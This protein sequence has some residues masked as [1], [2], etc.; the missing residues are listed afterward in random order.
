M[1]ECV[2]AR[3]LC[4]VP[5]QVNL[6]LSQL[7]LLLCLKRLC[8]CCCLLLPAG[9]AC[10]CWCC[11]LLLVLPAAAGAEPEQALSLLLPAAACCCLLPASAAC[12]CCLLV[13]GPHPACHVPSVKVCHP[14]VHPLVT[15]PPSPL[16]TCTEAEL[17]QAAAPCCCCL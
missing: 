6:P 5:K 10:C 12:W 13:R 7:S 16:I 3:F 1:I 8:P 2:D 4:H 15:S 11:L 17:P 9:A 14:H